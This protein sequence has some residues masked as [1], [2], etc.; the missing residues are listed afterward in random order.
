MMSL[1]EEAKTIEGYSWF[2]DIGR[3]C[4]KSSCSFTL[5]STS[6][7]LLL[8][9]HVLFIHFHI[10]NLFQLSA[11]AGPL[12]LSL[13]IHFHI[14]FIC[15]PERGHFCLSLSIH[16]HIF[17]ISTHFS[18]SGSTGQRPGMYSNANHQQGEMA[19]SSSTSSWTSSSTSSSLGQSR[20]TGG[21][22]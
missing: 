22:A 7:S 20:P 19:T 11:W 5:A 10:I 8:K 17:L 15:Q 16:F 4:C 1:C 2:G 18:L 21:K 12:F 9:V 3:I 14:F 6:C 13:S